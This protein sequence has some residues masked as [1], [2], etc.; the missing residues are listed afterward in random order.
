MLIIISPAKKL[1][2]K[3]SKKYKNSSSIHFSEESKQLTSILKQYK[4]QD[5]SILMKISPKLA[6]LNFERFI[7]WEYP[8]TSNEAGTSVNMFKGDV[9]QSLKAETFSKEDENYAQDHL[10]ILSGLYGV[11]K[12]LD[13]I[14]PYRLEMGTNLETKAGKNLYE[15][16]GDKIN[17]KIQDDL[18]AQGDN[19]LINLASNEYFKS[20]KVKNLTA[21]IIT[22]AFKEYKNGSYKMISIFAKKARGFMSRYIIENKLSDPEDL[23]GFD[24]EKYSFNE[25]LSSK[26]QFVFT[27]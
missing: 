26:D 15:F 17:K 27:R 13:I 2:N 8:F 16:W 22:P 10:R 7:K 19:I 5:L 23:K 20:I 9:Y 3:P 18:D 21:R 24:Y 14:L 4:P 12:P 6:E 11:L 1:D 25:E